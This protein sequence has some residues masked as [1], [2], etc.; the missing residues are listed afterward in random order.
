M[1]EIFAPLESEFVEKKRKNLKVVILLV[2]HNIYHFVDRVV[3]VT[4]FGGAY[5]LSHIDRCAVTAQKQL[6]V[7]AFG[8]QISPYRAVVFSVHYALF[9]TFKHF[10]FAFEV[11]VAFIVYLVKTD[12]HA[13]ICLIESR[14]NPFVHHFPASAH[15]LVS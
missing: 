4:Q 9:E 15:I 13:A 14:V 8:G 6:V 3:V 1:H 11:C 12:T 7:Q 10:L 5:V 2:A